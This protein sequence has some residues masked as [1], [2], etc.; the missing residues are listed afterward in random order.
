MGPIF[1]SGISMQSG[2]GIVKGI[3]ITILDCISL[4]C[5]EYR[6]S[7]GG[8]GLWRGRNRKWILPA[9]RPLALEPSPKEAQTHKPIVGYVP[10]G[11]HHNPMTFRRRLRALKK[12]LRL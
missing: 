12:W 7:D 3:S 5:R 4:T 9:N 1:A 11:F 10:K 2:R 6:I 8:C